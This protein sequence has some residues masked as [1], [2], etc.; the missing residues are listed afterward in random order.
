MSGLPFFAL[1]RE[2]QHLSRQCKDEKA[3]MT[4]QYVGLGCMLLMAAAS[5]AHLY[6]ELNG[7]RDHGRHSS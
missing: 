2:A 7:S 5:V 4:L 3:A 6:K 1:G